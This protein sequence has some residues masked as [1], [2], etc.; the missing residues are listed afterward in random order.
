MPCKE[1]SGDIIRNSECEAIRS[2][3]MNQPGIEPTTSWASAGASP[4]RFVKFLHFNYFLCT[5]YVNVTQKK[6]S[7]RRIFFSFVVFCLFL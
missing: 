1:S 3:G 4:D 6:I 5:V 7:R 2:F